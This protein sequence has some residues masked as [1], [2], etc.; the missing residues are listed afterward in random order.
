[1]SDKKTADKNYFSVS[2]HDI[3]PYDLKNIKYFVDDLAP[4]GINKFNL[5][6]IPNVEKSIP[7]DKAPELIKWLKQM[8]K[9]G[10]YITV[11]GL[12]HKDYYQKY[13]TLG[14]II[15]GKFLFNGYAE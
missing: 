15:V 7:I 2:I 10:N 9:K 6:V 4:L 12:Y 11:H 14:Q 1:M 13:N 8:Q 5:V 3:T